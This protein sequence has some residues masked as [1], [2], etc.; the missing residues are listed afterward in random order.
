MRIPK[1]VVILFLLAFIGAFGYIFL[2]KKN[3]TNNIVTT[4][5]GE[6]YRGSLSD[7]IF[8][9]GQASLANEQKL[10]F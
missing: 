1:I 4:S 10:R 6:V 3:S 5:T 7:S 9:T 8:I 2:S